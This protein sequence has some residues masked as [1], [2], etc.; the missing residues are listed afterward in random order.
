LARSRGN[1][2]VYKHQTPKTENSVK[3]LEIR[4]KTIPISSPIRNA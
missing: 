1:G 3:I 2:D 4:E